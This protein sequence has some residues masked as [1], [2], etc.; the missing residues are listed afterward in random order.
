[1]LHFDDPSESDDDSSPTTNGIE[2]IMMGRDQSQRRL[3]AEPASRRMPS[4]VYLVF[5]VSSVSRTSWFRNCFKSYIAHK[6]GG[7]NHVEPVFEFS[8]HTLEACT[9]AIDG[10][11][12][13]AKRDAVQSYDFQRWRIYE[14][15]LDAQERHRMYQFCKDQEGKNYNFR[16]VFFNFFC[17]LSCCCGTHD[18]DRDTWFCSH[19]V[20]AALQSARPREFGPYDGAHVNIGQLYN[21]AEHHNVFDKSIS[22]MGDPSQYPIHLQV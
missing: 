9:C 15:C 11:V 17:M 3:T 18:R 4:K 13:M 6:S 5:C 22:V 20:M 16:G 2:M 21:I 1:M 10:P 14:I 19:L 12:R 7:M 8:D